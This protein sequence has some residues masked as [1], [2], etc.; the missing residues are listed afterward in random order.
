VGWRRG[1]FLAEE[2]EG[3]W[4]RFLGGMSMDLVLMDEERDAWENN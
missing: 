2:A 1:F 4:T 3:E